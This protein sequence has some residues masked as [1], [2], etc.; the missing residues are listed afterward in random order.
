[1]EVEDVTRHTAEVEV[2]AHIPRQI[3]ISIQSSRRASDLQTEQSTNG[4]EACGLPR[5]PHRMAEQK[6]PLELVSAP[7][8]LVFK[9]YIAIP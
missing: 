1:M 9:Q 8:I 2:F 3:H 7:P 4:K 5:Y 6:I